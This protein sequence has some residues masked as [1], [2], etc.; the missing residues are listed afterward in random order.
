[1]REPQPVDKSVFG[2]TYPRTVGRASRV[3]LVALPPRTVGR[4]SSEVDLPQNQSLADPFTYSWSHIPITVRDITLTSRF[5][6]P[7][8]SCSCS[9]SVCG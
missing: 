9:A 7:L 8:T 6:Y 4:A 1:M 2:G 3:Q 5:I